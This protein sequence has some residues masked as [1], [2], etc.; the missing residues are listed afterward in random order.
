[1]VYNLGVIF[2]ED[3]AG[4]L[5]IV[6]AIGGAALVAASTHLV[7]WM[8]DYPRGRFRRPRAVRRFALIVLVLYGAAFTLGN[9]MYPTYKVRVKVE[10]FEEGGVVVESAAA[11]PRAA[12]RVAARYESA[13][14][15]RRGDETPAAAREPSDAEIAERTAPLPRAMNKVARW[16]DVKEHWTAIGLA[17]ALACAALLHAWRPERHPPALGWVAFALALG[18][19]AI[20]WFGAVIGLI[21]TSYRSI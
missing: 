8:R 7:V 6:H 17:L 3:Y 12:A 9:L 15:L 2:A 19:A 16:F 5:L 4:V 10:Y 1:M 13:A 18:L 11:R 21:T 14:A 20:T